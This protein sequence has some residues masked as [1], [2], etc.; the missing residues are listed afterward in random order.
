MYLLLIEAMAQHNLSDPA[1]LVAY[2]VVCRVVHLDY[3]TCS[4]VF[5]PNDMNEG[6][7]EGE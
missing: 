4:S 1:G 6:E 3:C 2:Y 5:I 7:G